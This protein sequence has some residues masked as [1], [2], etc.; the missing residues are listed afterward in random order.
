MIKN[1]APFEGKTTLAECMTLSENSMRSLCLERLSD[2]ELFKNGDRVC[3]TV[4]EWRGGGSHEMLNDCY[5]RAAR[6]FRNPE[7]CKNLKKYSFNTN[8]MYNPDGYESGCL[9]ELLKY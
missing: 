7:F 9:R 8:S 4:W 2:F 1:R 5:S 3:E 6:Y